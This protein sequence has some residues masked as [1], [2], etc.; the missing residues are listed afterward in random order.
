MVR[1]LLHEYLGTKV[2]RRVPEECLD[3]ELLYE[4]LNSLA[5]RGERPCDMLKNLSNLLTT[6]SQMDESVEVSEIF[7]QIIENLEE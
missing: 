4:P 5:I 1:P 3:I 6:L 7:D 2:L